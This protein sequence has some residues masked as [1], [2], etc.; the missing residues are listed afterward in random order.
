MYPIEDSP[1]YKLRTKRKLVELLGYAAGRAKQAG[2]DMI[3]I[4]AH[5]GYLLAQ[6]MSPYFNKRTDQ[7]GGTLDNRLR[8][9]FEVIDS[10]RRQVGSEFPLVVR[11]SID[12][13]VEGGRGIEE[14][15]ILAQRL[16][17]AG[18]DGITVTC[19]VHASK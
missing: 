17:Q 1:L 11:Y 7:Y 10:M 8:V 5:D 4:H 18:I 16:E 13:F 14:S 2:F 9:L 6:F 12:E 19:G 3:E 15:Q